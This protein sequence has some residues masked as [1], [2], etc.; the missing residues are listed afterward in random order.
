M[1]ILDCVQ[2]VNGAAAYLHP[3]VNRASR[4]KWQ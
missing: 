4:E 1:R 2:E 3:D